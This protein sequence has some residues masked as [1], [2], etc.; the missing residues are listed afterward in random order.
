M[1]EVA[2]ALTKG[3]ALVVIALICVGVLATIAAVLWGNKMTD[4]FPLW[5]DEEE[6]E[7]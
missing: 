3:A 2:W 6:D 4:E 5:M 7:L 1:I